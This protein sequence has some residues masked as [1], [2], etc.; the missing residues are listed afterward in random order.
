[1]EIDQQVFGKLKD[2]YG[3]HG[4]VARELGIAPRHYFNVRSGKK[5]SEA[6]VKLI[7]LFADANLNNQEDQACDGA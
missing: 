3:S 5:A 7:K 4:K 1:M 6:L 2:K